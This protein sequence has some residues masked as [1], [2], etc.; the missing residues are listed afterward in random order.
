MA[1]GNATW[2]EIPTTNFTRAITFYESVFG[3]SLNRETFG[4]PVEMAIFPST[5]ETD[6]SGCLVND[7]DSKPNAQAT[8]V[9]LNG[10]ADLA[11][12]LARVEKAGGKICVPKTE[13]PANM[14]FFAVLLDS[15][16]NR[17]GMHS[18]A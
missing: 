15:E 13:L 3:V 1:I 2:F 17:I 10:G 9:Y 11:V 16:G 14:G 8:T 12:P 6:V 5:G 7:P 18:M 4:G